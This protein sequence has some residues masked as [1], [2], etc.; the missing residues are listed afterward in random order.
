MEGCKEFFSSRYMFV[1]CVSLS[2]PPSLFCRLPFTTSVFLSPCLTPS[3]AWSNGRK[4]EQVLVCEGVHARNPVAC[5]KRGFQG[6]SPSCPWWCHVMNKRV[7]FHA[8][9]PAIPAIPSHH[10][11]LAN[12][13]E[14]QAVLRVTC[15]NRVVSRSSHFLPGNARILFVGVCGGGLWVKG[16]REGIVLHL[17]CHH[18]PQL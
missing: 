1:F 2:F 17:F 4:K 7:S 12:G 14:G 15:G 8:P 10:R 6:R 11:R 3:Q 5:E 16:G 18:W 9:I 13:P